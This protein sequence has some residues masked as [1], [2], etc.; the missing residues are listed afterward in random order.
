MNSQPLKNKTYIITGSAQGLGRDLAI[1]MNQQGASLVLIDK[2][3]DKL[4][5][6]EK[7]IFSDENHQ[8][9]SIGMDF[10]SS[11]YDDYETVAEIVQDSCDSLDGIIF[12][13]T[14]L[15][16]LSPLAHYEPLTWA[17]T[18][19]I[20]VHSNFLMYKT[21]YRQL[22]KPNGATL[23]FVLSPEVD[24]CKPNWGAYLVTKK[25]QKAMLELIAKEN[26]ETLINSFGIIP[27]PMNTS[28]RRQAYPAQDNNLLPSPKKNIE[29]FLSIISKPHLYRNGETIKV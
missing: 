3:L 28:L 7:N 22:K 9:L 27:R 13:A 12:N 16:S 24:E 11:T 25:T 6:L 21:M 18:F 4:K 20:N 2:Q 8:S 15:G 23:I 1:E 17:K 19:Q 14:N 10:L 26:S 5:K 29:K